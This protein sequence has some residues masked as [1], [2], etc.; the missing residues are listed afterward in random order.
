MLFDGLRP[1]QVSDHDGVPAMI[2]AFK[3]DTDEKKV[4]LGP[5]MYC[6]DDAKTWVLPAVKK[7]IATWFL[8]ITARYKGLNST[9]RQAKSCPRSRSRVF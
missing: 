2:E 4:N 1:E 9:M 8:S 3:N 6:D 5:G 7:V